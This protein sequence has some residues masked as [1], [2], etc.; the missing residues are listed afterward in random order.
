MKPAFS[1]SRATGALVLALLTAMLPA[2]A[3]Q[4]LNSIAAVVN[5]KVITTS[6]LQEARQATEQ[7]IRLTVRPGA[8][9]EKQLAEARTKALDQLIEREL[10]LYEFNK[11]GG[12]VK[13]SMIEEDIKKIIRE[14]FDG[15]RD[16]LIS[17]LKKT[18]MTLSKFEDLRKKMISLQVMRAQQGRDIVYA[19][20]EDVERAYE[21]NKDA[22]RSP[23]TVEVRMI[24]IANDLPGSSEDG[25]PVIGSTPGQ[26]EKLAR[27]IHAKLKAGADF[28]EMAKKYSDDPKASEGGYRGVISVDDKE[29]NKS[30][31]P[32]AFSL[33]TGEIS[34]L[35]PLS[36]GEGKPVSS[37]LILKA[38][39][40]VKG[41]PPTLDDP[42]VKEA[43]QNAALA[44]LREAAVKK[45]VDHLIKKAQIKKY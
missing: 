28:A 20:P 33:D 4:E 15:D 42:K 8:D 41:P 35:L 25:L 3:R 27:E 19:T 14:R 34:E 18:G 37:F 1:V 45:W 10:V 2:A 38:D 13:P 11:L 32:V 21:K 17:E 9:L 6:E 43:M 29:F 12:T 30:L 24:T 31:I 39:K 22:M 7:M 26:K 5:G 44:E 36:G 40:R 16:K 23:G